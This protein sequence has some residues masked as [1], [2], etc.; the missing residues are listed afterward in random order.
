FSYDMVGFG[1]RI[2]EGTRFYD[3]YP[4]WSKMGKMVAD[5]KGA[6][7]AL[8]NLDFVDSS[9][10]FITGYAMGAT[11]GLYATALD[12]RVAGLVSVSGFTP[13][14]TDSKENGREG[15]KAFSH[16]HGLIPRLGFFVGHEDRIPYDYQEILGSIAPRPVLVIAPKLDQT[17]N[18]T[19]IR[20]SVNEA[21]KIYKLLGASD[22]LILNSPD[23]FNRFTEEMQKTIYD[24]ARKLMAPVSN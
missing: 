8:S 1:N 3:R 18:L 15:I 6:V 14:R 5:A 17:A 19:D 2:E 22:Q 21:G 9:K 4:N 23:D 7:D 24:W 12:E 13:M 16:L 20:A 11:V 10:I